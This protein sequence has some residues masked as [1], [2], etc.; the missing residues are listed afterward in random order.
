MLFPRAYNH[1]LSWLESVVEYN[2]NC[3]SCYKCCV[4]V[5]N[6]PQTFCH[7]VTESTGISLTDVV[8]SVSVGAFLKKA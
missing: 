7:C 4:K 6:T 1:L 8:A 3:F 2:R 5:P